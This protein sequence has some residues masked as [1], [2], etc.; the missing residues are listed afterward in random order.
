MR[1]R[2]SY[3]FSN[4]M[5]GVFFFFGKKKKRKSFVENGLVVMYV[6]KKKIKF[7]FLI[8]HIIRITLI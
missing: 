1:P 6:E 7:L 5:A 8:R 3:F 4:T 2:I